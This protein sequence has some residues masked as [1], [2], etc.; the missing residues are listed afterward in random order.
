MPIGEVV[1]LDLEFTKPH[2]AGGYCNYKIPKDS[3]MANRDKVEPYVTQYQL[4]REGQVIV[5]GV[6][7]AVGGLSIGGET[8]DIS[9]KDYLHYLDKRFFPFDPTDV[10]KYEFV[11]VDTDVFTIIE[12]MLDIVLQQ[13]GSIDFFYAN[14]TSGILNSLKIDLADTSSILSKII[15]LSE[16]KPG[17]D[18]EMRANRHFHLYAPR[19]DFLSSY[20]VEQGRNLEELAYA[21]QGIEGTVVLGMSQASNSKIGSI[22]THVNIGKYGRWD[23]T[24]DFANIIDPE[25]LTTL[26]EGEADRSA[27]QQI[28]LTAMVIPQGSDNIWELIE[29]GWSVRVKADVGYD[30]I[31]GIFRCTGMKGSISNEGVEHVELTFDDNEIQV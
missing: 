8:I 19:K 12:D 1:P 13:P 30:S 24:H 9:G 21:E 23:H 22:V 17:F 28:E 26:T 25:T 31:D 14:G 15:T 20:I 2:D 4:F 29:P 27:N 6:H 3:P 10:S 16:Q 18:F 5:E 7:T 11:K